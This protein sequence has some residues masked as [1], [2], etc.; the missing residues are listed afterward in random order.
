MFLNVLKNAAAALLSAAPSNSDVASSSDRSLIDFTFEPD[1]FL[2]ALPT[3]G[4]CMLAIFCVMLIIIIATA[5]I[6]AVGSGKPKK[7]DDSDQ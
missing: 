6:N 2:Q 4:I 1:N 5:I 3:I 7:K